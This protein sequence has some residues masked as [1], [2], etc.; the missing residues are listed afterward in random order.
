MS[1]ENDLINFANDACLFNVKHLS[2]ERIIQLITL[3]EEKEEE[4]ETILPMLRN[5]I[6]IFLEKVSKNTKFDVSLRSKANRF[7]V[8]T[9][10][11][12]EN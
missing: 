9:V 8:R 5:A 1:L 7:I 11:V 6:S 3:I 2:L 4:W 10:I 12:E